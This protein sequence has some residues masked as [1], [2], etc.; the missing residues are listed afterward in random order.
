MRLEIFE[1]QELQRHARTTQLLVKIR[2]VRT[3][4]IIT[5]LRRRPVQPP[6]K[7]CLIRRLNRFPRQTGACRA[8]DRV[9]HDAHARID[10]PRNLSH[11]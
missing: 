10:A 8:I 5:W 11:R 1:V 9:L 2:R 6:L 3:R 7:R 4:T